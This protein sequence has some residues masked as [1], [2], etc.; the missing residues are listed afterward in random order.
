MKW[1]WSFLIL[2][3]VIVGSV[4]IW[5]GFGEPNKFTSLRGV[6]ESFA[7]HPERSAQVR[8]REGQRSNVLAVFGK[9]PEF[10][11]T[12]RSGKNFSKQ[13]LAGKPWL[14]DFIFTSCS[15]QCPLMSLQM[16]R[17][18]SLFGPGTGLRFVSFTVDPDRDTPGVLAQY[19]DR[20]EAEKD[21]WFFLTGPKP[22]IN[23]ILKEFFL[24]PVEEP[25]MHSIRF[26]LVDGE[27]G[28]RGY[29]DSSDP[30]SMNQLIY[31]ARVIAG[32]V[33]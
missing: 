5:I 26:I 25:A 7:R 9:T 6:P 21:R 29:Y 23:R 2:M 15:G 4:M 31:D 33:P 8:L 3:A 14:A 20:Y 19:A 13:D 24:S 30:A 16:K 1:V 11:L 12:E 17:F 32:T 10:S 22:E 18:Q 27:G 28:I